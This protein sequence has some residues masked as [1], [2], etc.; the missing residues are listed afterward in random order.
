MND[1]SLKSATFNPPSFGGENA[2]GKP[3]AG[4]GLAFD[5]KGELNA[6]SR[7]DAITQL[8][9]V[10]YHMA[11]AQEGP[12]TRQAKT[13][14][15]E[16]KGQYFA[17]LQDALNSHGEQGMRIVG[18]ELLNPV[19]E[20]IDFEGLSRKVWAPREVGPGEIPRYDR[21]V[22]VTAWT[23]ARDGVTPESKVTGRFVFPPE[24]LV[25]ADVIVDLR[26]I[27]T[28]QYDVLA[29]SQDRARQAIE[30]REDTATVN[31]LDT[32]STT[33]ND[34]VYSTQFDWNA[35]MDLKYQ[36]EKNRLPCDKF[37]INLA[38]TRDM[39]K[40]INYQHMDPVTMREVIMRGYIG[41]IA[42]VQLIASAG[43]G[44]FEPVPAGTV[45]ACSRPEYLGGMP[46]RIPLTSEPINKFLMG[47]PEKG[48]FFYEMIGMVVL[49]PRGV[50]KAVKS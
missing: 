21:D 5:D 25:S 50:A 2:W 17:A 30:Y 40:Y 14:T 27:Y 38:E 10:L 43:N 45:Y 48:W 29:R 7:N 39:L 31:L 6:Y 8:R 13:A 3:T 35:L 18:Q 37:L 19:R 4:E 26:D 12:M 34:V 22:Y 44:L 16:Q 24:F 47:L 11:S 15:A 36:I 41:N 28:M 1:V 33:V 42:G 49:N 9:S 23:V 32:A 46:V 20:I